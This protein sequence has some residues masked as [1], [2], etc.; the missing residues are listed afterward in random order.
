MVNFIFVKILKAKY[1]N[2]L[3]NKTKR[4][5]INPKRTQIDFNAE[6]C[7]KNGMNV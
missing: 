3:K 1:K 6:K 2:V 7:S 4:T 5:Q